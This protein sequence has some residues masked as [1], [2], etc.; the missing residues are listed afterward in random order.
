MSRQEMVTTWTRVVAVEMDRMDRWESSFCDGL[1][2]G[3]E[4]EEGSG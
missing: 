4:G 2:G 1:G 3:G